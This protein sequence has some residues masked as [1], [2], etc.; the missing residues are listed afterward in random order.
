MERR[1][2]WTLPFHSMLYFWGKI[3]FNKTSIWLLSYHNNE[4]KFQSGQGSSIPSSASGTNVSGLGIQ[5]FQPGPKVICC[6][7]AA[8]CFRSPKM[9]LFQEGHY[10]MAS[11]FSHCQKGPGEYVIII[12]IA[13]PCN[14]S[15]NHLIWVGLSH[16]MSFSPARLLPVRQKYLS[17]HS[18]HCSPWYLQAVP[19]L[20]APP[21]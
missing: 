15:C 14:L 3:P 18:L 13:C 7:S 5:T 17:R 8:L 20:G 9:S 16:F 10:I 12:C 6:T 1:K 11:I 19:R 2:K 4:V 21:R